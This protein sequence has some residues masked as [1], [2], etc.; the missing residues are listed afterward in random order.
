MGQYYKFIILSDTKKNNKEVILLVI[1][2]HDFM[3]GAK[4]MEH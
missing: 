2:P 4:L 1:N 3:E